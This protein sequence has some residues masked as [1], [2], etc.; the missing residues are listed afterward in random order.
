[1]HGNVQQWCADPQNGDNPP[2]LS[3]R[4]GAWFSHD[5]DCRSAARVDTVSHA[6]QGYAGIRIVLPVPSAKTK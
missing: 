2:L 6:F 4:G 1:M 5:Q 3:L